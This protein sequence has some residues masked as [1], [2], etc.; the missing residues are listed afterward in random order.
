MTSIDSN[1]FPFLEEGSRT[2]YLVSDP[3]ARLPLYHEACRI[4]DEQQQDDGR[5]LDYDQH[6]ARVEQV[7]M[8]LAHRAFMRDT[9]Q[10]RR[11]KVNM[12]ATLLPDPY[13]VL[14]ADGTLEFSRWEFS[15]ETLKALQAI[16][17]IINALARQYGLTLKHPES[18]IRRD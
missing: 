1:T 3:T 18:E 6:A 15:G 12:I 14:Q 16:D 8:A 2:N 11:V 9:E 17:E 10:F 7:R 13:V 4:V 5:P